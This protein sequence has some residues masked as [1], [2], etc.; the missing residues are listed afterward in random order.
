MGLGPAL[1]IFTC[2]I[3]LLALIVWCLGLFAIVAMRALRDVIQNML[4]R[5]RANQRFGPRILVGRLN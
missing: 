3:T 2:G 4:K 5:R 1:V